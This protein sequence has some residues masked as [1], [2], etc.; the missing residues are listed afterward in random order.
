MDSCC[1]AWTSVEDAH[2]LLKQYFA[3][4]I[5]TGHNLMHMQGW[6][7]RYPSDR[8]LSKDFRILAS[9]R[10]CR[11]QVCLYAC[12]YGCGRSGKLSWIGSSY[13]TS[14]EHDLLVVHVSA[15]NEKMSLTSDPPSACSISHWILNPFYCPIPH[16][17]WHRLW[18]VRR[19][20][21]MQPYLVDIIKEI[22]RNIYR[23]VWGLCNG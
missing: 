19:A 12:L 10:R 20:P 15:N 17:S 5:N 2:W 9:G 22:R 1:V 18:L 21:L 4:S 3:A 13:Y 6:A 7:P 8:D 23:L 11:A 16:W 14:W